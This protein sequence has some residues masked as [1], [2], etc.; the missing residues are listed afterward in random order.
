MAS[1]SKFVFSPERRAFS[2]FVL[3]FCE[4]YSM[5]KQYLIN[6]TYNYYYM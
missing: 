6:Q 4:Y 3:W 5:F 2:Y 1:N